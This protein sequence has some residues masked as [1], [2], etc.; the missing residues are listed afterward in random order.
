MYVNVYIDP[1]VVIQCTV[2]DFHLL[3]VKYF[4]MSVYLWRVEEVYALGACVVH[5][6]GSKAPHYVT[7][8][9][10]TGKQNHYPGQRMKS[11]DRVP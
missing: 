7:R 1:C 9:N 4:R 2:T 8:V 3:Q 10:R 6:Q 11:L 5:V